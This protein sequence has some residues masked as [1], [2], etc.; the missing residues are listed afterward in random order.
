MFF[1]L[2]TQF[3]KSLP[4]RCTATV[5]TADPIPNMTL[6]YVQVMT[7]HGM[8]TPIEK[9][10]EDKSLRGSWEC[11]PI[12]ALASRTSTS[13]S[14]HYR[15][16]HHEIDERLLPYPPSCSNG[17]LTIEGMEQHLNVGKLYR[18]HLV[19][20]L[21]FLPEKFDPQQFSFVSSPV[22]RCFRSAESFIYGLYPPEDPNEVIAIQTG[23]AAVSS[24]VIPGENCKEAS[25][26][27][28]DFRHSQ[29]YDD[30]INSTI[31]DLREPLERFKLDKTFE[32]YDQ[33]CSWV[34]SF[35]CNENARVPSF[36]SEKVVDTCYR[37]CSFNQFG[38][39]KAAPS[40]GLIAS[41]AV[42]QAMK[43]ADL[44]IASASGKKFAL[45]SAHDTTV[46][47]YLTLLGFSDDDRPPPYASHLAMEL[48][49]DEHDQL[50]VRYVFNGDEVP[51]SGFSNQTLVRFDEFR[52][53][54][55]PLIDYCK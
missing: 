32:G 45:F 33:L 48:W 34:V 41:T 1:L 40:P 46:A 55:A 16:V 10:P 35:T 29:Q 9:L 37:V 13:P 49:K 12:D 47:A 7:R 19:D 42:R 53:Y 11:N 8:R 22:D 2:L 54:I 6:T 23:S 27:I 14:R 43:L 38:T 36:I 50:Y 25:D 4:D 5:K 17:D 26:F 24:L 18:K 20:D 44:A 28:N 52:S 51:L 39:F 3:A 31:D 15:L 30:F 21:H